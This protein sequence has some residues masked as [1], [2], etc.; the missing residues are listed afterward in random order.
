MSASMQEAPAGSKP[1]SVSQFWRS[2]HHTELAAVLLMA[3]ATLGSSW[4][5]FQGSIWN[6]IQ[7]FRLA[8]A[9]GL[10]RLAS[11]DRL[12]ANQHLNLDAALFLA[13]VRSV[14]EDKQQDATFVLA[15]MRPEAQKAMEAWLATDP[16]HGSNAPSSPFVMSAYHLQALS[17]AKE[18]GERSAVAY[19]Q[20]RSANRN[21]DTCTM[22]TV[23]FAVA[24]FLAGVV[25]GL[26]EARKQWVVIGLSLA[27]ICLASLILAT[28]P[29]VHRA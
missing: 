16:R 13:Y 20:A 25:T 9:A 11:E 1:K 3:L 5:G 15:R 23:F 14:S 22:L 12:E 18:Q 19:D 6:G 26:D 7:I 8:D 2:K 29:I 24:L 27:M 28:L 10:E 21:S 17:D 4:S